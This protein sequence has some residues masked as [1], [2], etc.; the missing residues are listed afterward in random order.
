M[1]R[2]FACH[3]TSLKCHILQ[4]LPTFSFPR[5]CKSPHYDY[6]LCFCNQPHSAF[7]QCFCMPPYVVKM[8]YFANRCTHFL[9]RIFAY[10]YISFLFHI[11][12]VPTVRFCSVLLQVATLCL[13]PVISH[14]AALRLCPVLLPASALCFL[15]SALANSCTPLLARVFA[16]LSTVSRNAQT[17]N[18]KGTVTSLKYFLNSIF[19]AC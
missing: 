7:V 9:Y 11:F 19:N 2:V 14:I 17:I 15:F 6:V 1:F 18:I 16:S 4:I 3:R 8:L 12:T 13:C 5:F 10:R